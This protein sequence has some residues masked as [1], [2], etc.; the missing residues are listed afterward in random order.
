ME[1]L[2]YKNF[3]KKLENFRDQNYIFTDKKIQN[4]RS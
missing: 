4:I 1:F 2:K 3:I